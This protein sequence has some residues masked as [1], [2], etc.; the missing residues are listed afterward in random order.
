MV[1]KSNRLETQPDTLAPYQR[2]FLDVI[3]AAEGGEYDIMYG[4]EG[5][6]R[7]T[8]FSDHPRNPSR[9]EKGDM[10]AR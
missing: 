7:I 8:D 4:P 9:I 3:A 5:K 1:T 10:L 6:G 2:A